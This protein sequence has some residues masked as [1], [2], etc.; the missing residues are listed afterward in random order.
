MR[1]LHKAALAAVLVL[2][3]VAGGFVFPSARDVAGPQ[4]FKQVFNLVSNR[5]VDSLD[6]S[7]IYEKAARGLVDELKDP[8]AALYDPDQLKEF[9]TMTEGHY[10][11]VGMLV[12]DQQGTVV[13]SRV[14]PHTPAEEAGILQGDR[15]VGVDGKSTA[16]WSLTRVTNNL[17]GA[18]GSKVSASF[19]RPGVETPIVA[20]FTRAI[21][22]IPAVPYATLVSGDIGYIPILQ[23]NE[24]A[25]QETRD[26]VEKLE[27]EGAKS[28]ILDMR[29]N[30]GGIV[31]QAID[32]ANLF[33]PQGSLVATQKERGGDDMDYTAD[34]PPV[35][36]A[37]PLVVLQDGQSASATEIITGALQDHD[38]ALV[39]GTRSFGKG[40]VQSVYQ[41]DGG[42][43][44][45]MTTGKWYTPSG[46]TIHRDRKLVNGHLVLEDTM[47]ADS[48]GADDQS[49][50]GR[51]V[52]HSDD[53][54]VLYGGGGITPDVVVKP[55]TLSG[56]EQKLVKEMIPHSQDV[57]LTLYKYAFQL[58]SQVKPGFSVG[59]QWREEFYRRLDAAGVKLDRGDYD[60]AHDYVDRI[61]EDK[62]ATLAF[63]DAVA[64]RQE[65]DEDAQLDKAVQLLR[66]ATT[67]KALFA[68]ASAAHP[69]TRN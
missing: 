21:I 9:A 7:A 15:I 31:T 32:I 3:F 24:T 48:A 23:I 55:D 68:S 43:A 28:I 53:G 13:V 26:A 18:P 35:A 42:Y 14:F 12:E 39:V 58:K 4:L 41:L 66:Q 57:Y 22:H 45:K 6:T 10:A 33:L 54:R 11:G 59:P 65:L 63:G 2:T 51:P 52:Y 47:S 67:Q 8:Y 19:S 36:L 30:G 61:L 38:R 49:T 69:G 44:L 1:K 5:Y 50:E 62:V 56:A 46:R 64:K 16:G 29:G 34:R 37:L 40:L 27:S 17:K 20:H 60:A 25:A